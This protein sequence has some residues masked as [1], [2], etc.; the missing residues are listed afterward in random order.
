MTDTD[1][2]H[3]LPQGRNGPADDQKSEGH[4]HG[5][6]RDQDREKSGDQSTRRNNS[7]DDPSSEESGQENSAPLADDEENNQEKDHEGSG[8]RKDKRSDENTNGETSGNGKSGD[9]QSEA[10]HPDD[11]PSDEPTLWNFSKLNDLFAKSADIKVQMHRLSKSNPYS[12]IVLVFADGLCESSLIG[13][14]ILPELYD[15][16][17]KDGLPSKKGELLAGKLPLSMLKHNAPSSAVEEAVFQGSVVLFLPH[18]NELYTMDISN[19]PKRTP[20]ESTTEISV[21]GPKDGFTEDIST[22]V[23]LIR[24]RLRSTTL[25][26]ETFIMGRRTR[27]RVSLLYIDDIISPKLLEEVKKRMSKIDMDGLYTA[28]QLEELLSDSKYSLL[29]L[30]DFTGR[31]D[32]AVS[33]LINGRFVI[34]VDGNPMVL[35]GPGSL[36]LLMKSP[37]DIHFNYIYVS[38]VR[39][40]RVLSLVLSVA[41]PG[42]WV[43]LTAFHQDQIPYRMLATISVTRLGL[44]FSA[45]MELFLLLLLFEIFREAGIRLPTTIGQT[46]TVIGG[47]IIGDAAI[48]AGLVSPSSVV[49]GAITTVTGATLVN[50]SLTS[51]I[52]VIRFTLFLIASFLGMYGLILGLIL[53]LIYVSRL[54]TFGE[55]YLA[56]VSPFRFKDFI[57]SVIRLPWD[58]VKSRTSFLNPKDPDHQG[59]S[60][61]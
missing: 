4:S 52:S 58:K 7:S 11:N 61:T 30:I 54:R 13:K 6:K 38:F 50:Q 27:T 40:I 39:L 59:E 51:V 44:P 12:E 35:T 10:D 42:F 37:E 25:C 33:S 23:A 20:E 17:E 18:T 5:D 9:N 19:M 24:K 34:I 47:L 46:L 22:N 2:R 8:H 53:L 43:A 3:S 49:V 1:N 60:P 41:L 28:S 57:N 31:P 56:P 48:R 32:Y 36:S 55:S 14:V 26:N 16:Y 29:P 15:M 45:Q 21:K